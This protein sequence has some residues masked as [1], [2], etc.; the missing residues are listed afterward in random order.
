MK[1]SPTSV[2]ELRPEK[3]QGRIANEAKSVTPSPPPYQTTVL[4]EIG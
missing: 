1:V 3:L 2:D 4:T